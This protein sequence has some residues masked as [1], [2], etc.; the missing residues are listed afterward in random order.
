MR[1]NGCPWNDET[2][3]WAA[4]GGH[5]ETLRW[6]RVNGAPWQPNIRRRAAKKLGYTDDIGNLDLDNDWW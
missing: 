4:F 5:L 6:A 2:C 3:K 1:A